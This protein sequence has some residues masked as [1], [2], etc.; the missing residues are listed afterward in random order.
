MTTK[1]TVGAPTFKRRNR[2]LVT[3]ANN[4]V[5]NKKISENMKRGYDL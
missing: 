2:C 5:G 4:I 1:V 3:P